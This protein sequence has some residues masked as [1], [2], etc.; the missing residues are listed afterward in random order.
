MFIVA[1]YVATSIKTF[2]S[3]THPLCINK[4]KEAKKKIE[5]KKKKI[6][7]PDLCKSEWMGTG[8]DWWD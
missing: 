6:F 2:F 7:K 5:K 4:M 1:T 3:N 8:L